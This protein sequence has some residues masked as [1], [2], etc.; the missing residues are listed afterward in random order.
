MGKR[1]SLG[2]A[3]VSVALLAVTACGGGEDAGPEQQGEQV[4]TKAPSGNLQAWGFDNADDVGKARLE[5]AKQQLSGVN[6]TL[7][8]TG[9]DA[10]KFTTR[11][12]SGQVPDVVQ[13]DRQFVATYAAQ[14]LIQPLDACF[15]AWGV[16]PQ[17]YYYPSVT[18]DVTYQGKVWAVPQFFQP[19]AIIVNRRVLDE[20][21]VAPED[22]DPSK[23]DALVA[24][25]AKLYRAEGGN[26]ARMGFDPVATGQAAL[27]LLSFGGRL[28]DEEGKPALNDPKNVEAVAYL[29][30]LIDAQGGW[31][32]VKSFTDSFDVFGKGNQYVKDQ[33]AAQVNAQWYVNVL[34][35]YVKQIE[36]GAVPFRD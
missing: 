14:E 29:K 1:R 24:T 34:S 22:I 23:G 25:A 12:A 15:T 4:F 27:W 19:A 18:A 6:I 36:I 26:P 2:A 35:P 7:D 32:K 31:A 3:L 33:V 21:G 30:R 11:L 28:V 20:A 13:M 9:F 16:D 17:T 8:Q 10:Q 5:H